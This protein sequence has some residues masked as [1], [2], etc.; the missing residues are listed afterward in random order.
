MITEQEQ[1]CDDQATISRMEARIQDLEAM[2]KRLEEERDHANVRFHDLFKM[3]SE[4]WKEY[5]QEHAILLRMRIYLSEQR[6]QN[7]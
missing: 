7:A 2:N 5:Q 1:F 3:H 4:L 6:Q